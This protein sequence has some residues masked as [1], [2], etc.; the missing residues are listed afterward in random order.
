MSSTTQND[1][2]FEDAVTSWIFR[3][4]MPLRYALDGD[5]E[6]L[7]PLTV[8]LQ[9]TR[10]V[11]FAE[12]TH[13]T[14]EFFELRHRLLQFLV[15]R[16]GFNALAIEASRSAAHA[17]ND[18]I[19]HGTGERAEVLTGLGFVM[20]DVEEFAQVL[21][22]LRN[23]NRMVPNGQQVRFYGVDIWNTQCARERVLEYVARI[24]PEQAAGIGTIL[25]MIGEAE[26]HGM[27][28]AHER[29]TKEHYRVLRDLA[30]YLAGC[31]EGP[32]ATASRGEYELVMEDLQGLLQWL[33]SCLTDELVEEQPA[34]L[35]RMVTLNNFARSK[36]MA[37]NLLDIVQ[38]EPAAKI[39][40]WGHVFHLGFGFDYAD[41]GMVPTMG[42]HLRQQLDEAYYVFGLELNDGQ[43]L[44]R[45]RLAD[46]TLGDLKVGCIPS[47][48]EGSLPWR[49]TK[50]AVPCV[51][52]N[53][54]DPGAAPWIKEW[55]SSPQTLHAVSW[56]HRDPPSLYTSRAPAKSY[57]GIIQIAH[58]SATTPTHNAVRTVSA[59]S[60]Y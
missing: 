9:L 45:S 56:V 27:M 7:Q 22:W 49:L 26:A 53:L 58:T 51:L 30:D 11:G 20:W 47:A 31:R 48:P 40:L 14:K 37:E 59:R 23:Y 8:L 4:A 28:L 38:H 55:L 16:M 15:T 39:V 36:F 25:Q 41:Q 33:R 42:T 24:V 32:V 44:A 21:D 34:W 57:D 29:V 46:D 60:G 17:V 18:Y 52:L 13:G 5:F 3:Q 6:D 1:A 12:C 50:T 43:Y 10:V 35:P 19:L 54:R 2:L